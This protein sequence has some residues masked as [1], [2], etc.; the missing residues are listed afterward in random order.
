MSTAPYFHKQ[1]VKIVANVTCAWFL[2]AARA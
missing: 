1:H 2:I